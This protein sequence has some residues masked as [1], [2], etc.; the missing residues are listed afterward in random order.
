MLGIAAAVLFVIAFLINAAEVTT[1]DVFSSVNLMLL[2]L[3]LLALHVAGVGA[4]RPSRR[5]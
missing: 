4:G 5:R 3:A 2:G 1:N